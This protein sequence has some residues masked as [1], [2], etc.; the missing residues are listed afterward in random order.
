MPHTITID[1]KKTLQQL[2]EAGKYDWKYINDEYKLPPGKKGTVAIE[3][4]QVGHQP[5][6]KAVVKALNA[7]GYRPATIAE[8]LALGIKYKKLQRNKPIASAEGNFYVC[9]SEYDGKRRLSVSQDDHS[10]LDYCC[11]AA[12][13]KSSD[14][15]SLGTSEL[16]SLA[17]EK[18]KELSELISKL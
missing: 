13:R 18:I 3:L 5:N 9:L 2:V 15:R 16:K 10:W 11:F 8:V 6:N 14:T 4:V 1:P 17:L 12:V 7:K